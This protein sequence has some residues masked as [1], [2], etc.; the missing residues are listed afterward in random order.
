MIKEEDYDYILESN[1]YSRISKWVLYI[2]F[3]EFCCIE[4]N[5]IEL[6]KLSIQFDLK[7]F[8]SNSIISNWIH[9]IFNSIQIRDIDLKNWD[10]EDLI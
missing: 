2:I 7:F 5:L 10:Y 3:F 6:N 1:I 4:L 9:D 8:E